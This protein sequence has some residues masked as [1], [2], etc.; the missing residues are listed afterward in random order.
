[1]PSPH[2]QKKTSD[3]MDPRSTARGP[4]ASWQDA[5][6]SDRPQEP[7]DL[8]ERS[9]HLA[10]ELAARDRVTGLVSGTGDITTILDAVLET[11][12]A[13]VERPAGVVF[14]LNEDTSTLRVGAY[15]N[16]PWRLV[17][18]LAS[19][20][21]PADEG[22]LGTVLSTGRPV[23]TEQFRE[24]SPMPDDVRELV[25]CNVSIMV[26]LRTGQ[27]MV[28]VLGVY[29][30]RDDRPV[31]RDEVAFLL[32]VGLQLGMLV[33]NARLAQVERLKD[34]FLSLVSHELRTPT[35]TIRAGLSTLRRHRRSLDPTVAD[36]LLEDMAEESERLHQL[37]EDLLSLTA[38]QRGGRTPT[39]PVSARP[40]ICQV[41]ELMRDRTARHQIRLDLPA[42]LPAVEAE[43]S[44][45][46]HVVRNLLVNALTYSPPESEI[47]I[48]AEA[49]EEHVVFSVLDR[50]EGIPVEELERVFQPFYRASRNRVFISGAGLGL[51]V[52]RRLLEAQGGWI[53]AE[54][55]PGGGTSFRF[56]LPVAGRSPHSVG[57]APGQAGA[58]S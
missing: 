53:W 34:D 52:C 57:G 7:S 39:E 40:L 20:A 37:I 50:G 4:D 23:V 18:K 33:E 49:A 17:A 38:Q 55:R 28:G 58:G 48:T 21:K 27:R 6:E 56:R 31:E 36:Q 44:Y 10:R 9:A 13:A 11:V 32:G 41:L 30:P 54:P 8:V 29:D 24:D 16:I 2:P 5:A 51:T 3:R 1:M 45:F 47:V 14:L 26:P 35:T 19:R 15:R 43:P 46:Q 12:L 22:L 42:S 25:A